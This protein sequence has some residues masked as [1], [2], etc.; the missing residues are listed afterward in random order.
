MLHFRRLTKQP[1]PKRRRMSVTKESNMYWT[2]IYRYQYETP[3]TTHNCTIQ[4]S[5]EREAR[6]SFTTQYSGVVIIECYKFEEDE[7]I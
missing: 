5:S 7:E 1:K 3:S 2:I 4:S 6:I